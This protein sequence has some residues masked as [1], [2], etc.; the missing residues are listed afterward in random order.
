MKIKNNS[1]LLIIL[2]VAT[3]LRF[4]NYFEIPFTHDEFSALFRTYF[5]NFSTLIEKGVKVDTHPAGVQVFLYYLTKLFG[6]QAWVVKLP[7]TIFGILS[8]YLIYLIAKQWYNESVGL[9]SAA[10]LASIQYAIVYSQIA[11]PYISGLFFSLLMVYYWSKIIRNPQSNFYKN[12]VLY[13]FSSAICAYNHHFSLLF[14]AIVGITGVFFIQRKYLVRYLISGVAIFIL[15]IPHLNIFFS[16][17]GDKGVEGWL[18]KPTIS[19]FHKYLGY[20]FHFSWITVLVVIGII[21][22]G[23]M[24]LNR[25]KSPKGKR[26]IFPI[27]F[28]LP[29]LI[30]FFYS[31][32]VN[33]VIQYSV[34]IFSFPYLFFILFGHIKNLKAQTNILIV[35]IILIANISTLIAKRHH[36]KLLYNDIHKQVFTD[37]KKAKKNHKKID[38][39]IY[40]HAKISR[41]YFQKLN[42]DTNNIHF[43]E[44][45]TALEL[46]QFL[47][48][49]KEKTDY[50]YLGCRSDI[51]PDYI[52]VILDYY[53]NIV[54]KNNYFIGA[55]YLFTN[56]KIKG[57]DNISV[58][59]SC[60]FEPKTNCALSGI[61]KQRITEK[62]SSSGNHS[63]H[64][65]SLTTYSPAYSF[66]L[67]DIVTNK[68]SF[69][70]ISVKVLPKDNLN[71]IHLVSSIESNEEV[72]YWGGSLSNNYL[73]SDSLNKKWVTI[74]HAVKIPDLDI[75]GQQSHIKIYIWNKPKHDF[76][77]DDFTIKLRK[78]NPYLY[79]LVESI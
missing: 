69:I 30:G 26:I 47:T 71:G 12:A 56:K 46:K 2:L 44:F 73:G 9:I 58:I 55:T 11:R 51:D 70:D 33:A 59:E 23:F 29:I 24:H 41:Y 72:L 54:W 27:W 22:L 31:V 25:Q 75:G 42:I 32:F 62:V 3:A 1:I 66:L 16:Q 64:I 78:G 10:F 13:V 35:A 5:N 61:N 49:A 7:F 20:I 74:Y 36:Y 4:Y 6:H 60:D 45:N 68:N 65:D 21:V 18:A 38:F 79:G 76:F 77:I 50:L 52:P 15:Y 37:Y 28:I 67:K 43:N 17:L 57:L 53:P 34:L 39:I 40:S 8:V 48:V 63:Y 14:A 19:F